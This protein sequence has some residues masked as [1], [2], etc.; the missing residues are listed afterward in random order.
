MQ[1]VLNLEGSRTQDCHGTSTEISHCIIG[2]WDALKYYGSTIP[3]NI[4]VQLAKLGVGWVAKNE[5]C[6][7]GSTDGSGDLNSTM[8]QKAGYWYEHGLDTSQQAIGPGG[9]SGTPGNGGVGG[10]GGNGGTAGNGGHGTPGTNANGVP[11]T[12]ANGVSGN[13]G[14]GGNGG[15]GGAGGAGGV[16]GNG[17]TCTT[18]PCNANGGNANGGNGGNANGGNSNGDDN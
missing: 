5:S 4:G 14:I 15:V 8:Q 2:Y 18:S 12:N 3:F 9:T 17:G 7:Y 11:G 1:G 16:G 13:G 6:S 10:V